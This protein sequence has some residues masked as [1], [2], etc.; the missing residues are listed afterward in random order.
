M[1]AYTDYLGIHTSRP[2]YVGNRLNGKSADKIATMRD[3]AMRI[4]DAD[5]AIRLPVGCG[6][7]RAFRLRQTQPINLNYNS[8][9]PRHL[10]IM[11]QGAGV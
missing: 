1:S 3:S 7:S 10:R 9:H 4:D 2:T 11:V 6:R 8:C 5:G